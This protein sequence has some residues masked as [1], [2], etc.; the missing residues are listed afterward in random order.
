[1]LSCPTFDV[2]V[3]QNNNFDGTA[4]MSVSK[5]SPREALPRQ[6]RLTSTPSA[7]VATAAAPP[8]EKATTFSGAPDSTSDEHYIGGGRGG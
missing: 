8:R 1:M 4:G 5:A 3:E 2:Q 7:S 6:L